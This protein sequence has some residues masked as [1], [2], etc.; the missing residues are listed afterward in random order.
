MLKAVLKKKGEKRKIKRNWFFI[1]K[2]DPK[3]SDQRSKSGQ[4]PQWFRGGYV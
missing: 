3:F 1:G 4:T 2:S